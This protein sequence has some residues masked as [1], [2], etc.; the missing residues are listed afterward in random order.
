MSTDHLVIIKLLLQ[1][2]AFFDLNVS[3]LM[4]RE[5]VAHT[6]LVINYTSERLEWAGE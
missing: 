6:N 1:N 3:K 5:D 4:P 2:L